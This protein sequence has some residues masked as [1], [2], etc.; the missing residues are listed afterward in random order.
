MTRSWHGTMKSQVTHRVVG[1][2]K[3]VEAVKEGAG[4]DQIG[5]SKGAKR[6][7][8]TEPKKL[9]PEP[10]VELLNMN[11]A[12]DATR[13]DSAA[14]QRALQPRPLIDHYHEKFYS[15]WGEDFPTL[16]PL[17][18]SGRKAGCIPGKRRPQCKVFV[19]MA[20]L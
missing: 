18:L 11:V 6:Q 3:R 17:S 1:K 14:E 4:G 19:P 16:P 13:W 15:V 2:M 7:R 5:D 12:Q 9:V 8:L 10:N 20:S